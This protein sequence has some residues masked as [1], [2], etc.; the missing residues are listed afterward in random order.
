M[1]PGVGRVAARLSE[2]PKVIIIKAWPDRGLGNCPV[3]GVPGLGSMA[4]STC[5]QHQQSL[6]DLPDVGAELE[7]TPL[8]LIIPQQQPRMTAASFQQLSCLH[9]LQQVEIHTDWFVLC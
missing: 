7:H 8:L 5:R 3:S 6:S 1:R 2:Q 9:T 4:L